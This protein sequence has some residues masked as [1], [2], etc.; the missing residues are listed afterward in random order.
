M[1]RTAEEL[2]QDGQQP[3]SRGEGSVFRVKSLKKWRATYTLYM[4]DDGRAVQVSGTGDTKEQAIERRN[5]NYRKHLVK[6][7][8]LPASALK[9][10]PL[11]LKQNTE[12]FL[13]DWLALKAGGTHGQKPSISENVAVR[14]QGLIR[15]HIN[16]HIGNIPI[17]LLSRKDIETLLFITLPKKRKLKAGAETDEPLLGATPL[18]TV[19]AIVNMACKW[20]VNEKIL[21]EN[22]TIGIPAIGKDEPKFEAIDK[23]GWIP[24]RIIK[25]LEGNEE[26]AR[27]ILAF[28]GL[29]Q[30]ERLGVTWDA[31]TYLNDGKKTARLA[32]RQ[33]LLRNE[34]TGELVLKKPKSQSGIR[35]IPLD[36]RV[37]AIIRKHKQRQD[38]WKKSPDWKP[39]E[40][41]ED[42][43]FTT[44]DGKPIRH[45]TDNKQWHK[46]LEENGIP[47]IRQH[48]M[49]HIAISAMIED[50]TP[51]E[52]V[53]AYAGHK[54]EDLT[55]G[56]YTHLG[57]GASKNA[58]EGLTDNLFRERDK[59][60]NEA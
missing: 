24:R 50:G 60:I 30:G 42:L 57:A 37:T 40:G 9:T 47:Y 52:I 28:Y 35:V 33:Q 15:N 39:L 5:L 44:K 49:R 36:K 29:R 13:A 38:E 7:G 8:E 14:Y 26:E 3:R 31:F 16:P 19:Q 4:D 51:I 59:F 41:L 53:R 54:K 2:A 12:S 34:A 22:P 17:R 43:A 45:Q 58:V 25:N 11:E 23:K 56:T 10:R 27:W 46:L 32:I 20:G 6:A 48:A 21:M 18:R 1:R 55:R